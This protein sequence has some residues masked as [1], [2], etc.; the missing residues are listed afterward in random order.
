MCNPAYNTT[1]DIG[2]CPA[3]GI[4]PPHLSL[5]SQ[6][7]SMSSTTEKTLTNLTDFVEILNPL[8]KPCDSNMM[9][10]CQSYLSPQQLSQI[11]IGNK[12]ICNC[13]ILVGPYS[14]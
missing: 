3:E 13:N 1:T 14:L 8:V 7:M 4:H 9:E 5:E 6:N 11:I 10:Q 12:H 2:I